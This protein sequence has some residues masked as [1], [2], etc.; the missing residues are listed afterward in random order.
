MK[1]QY[2]VTI[3]GEIDENE[4]PCEDTLEE[5]LENEQYFYQKAVNNCSFTVK[6]LE[7]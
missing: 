6:E 2:L 1:K 7:D 3:E 5:V 4:F